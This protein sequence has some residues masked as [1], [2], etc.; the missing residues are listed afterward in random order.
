MITIK[1]LVHRGGAYYWTPSPKLR[2]AGWPAEALGRD[3]AAAI[4]RAEAIN[5]QVDRWLDGAAAKAAR[6]ADGRRTVADLIADYKGSRHYLERRAST[7]RGYDHCLSMIRKIFGDL[8]PSAITPVAVED[9]YT[10]MCKRTASGANATFR[11]L[12]LLLAH[13]ERCGDIPKGS[14]PCRSMKMTGLPPTGRVW[15]R[16]AVEA[17]VAAADAMG[18]HSMGTAVL[19]NSWAGQRQGDI[20]ALTRGQYVDGELR[21]R[22]SKT[23]A[24]VAPAVG[25]VPAIAARLAAE[26]ARQDAA[27]VVALRDAADRPLIVCEATGRAWKAD[28][29]R[30]A[31]AE[32]R[33]A[34]A[35]RARAAG[36]DALAAELAALTFLHLRH[37]AITRL[38]EAGAPLQE[39]ADI[40]GHTYA[41]VDKIMERYLVRTGAMGRQA[42]QRRLDAEGRG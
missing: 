20:L 37:T 25:M 21:I 29:F 19:V 36:D 34:A 40:T 1:Y 4:A 14:N 9:A 23:G 22:Q 26:T 5:A 42:F 8:R 30:H 3:R 11:V 35:E 28:H 27:K 32:V 41:S 12:R 7:R 24:A 31:F 17:F 33:A 10:R 38:A 15:S 39:I 6:K 13:G 18:R 2:K 16:Q